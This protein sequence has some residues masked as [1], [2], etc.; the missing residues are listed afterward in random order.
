MH[1]AKPATWVLICPTPSCLDC[2][3]M[4]RAMRPDLDDAPFNQFHVRAVHA[5]LQA[6][7]NVSGL[8]SFA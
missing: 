8:F 3:A 6:A 4:F 5:C 7:N 2:P 1:A